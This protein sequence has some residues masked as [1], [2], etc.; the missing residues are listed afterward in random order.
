MLVLQIFNILGKYY[1]NG[2]GQL[3]QRYHRDF[4]WD[5]HNREEEQQEEEEQKQ[6]EQDFA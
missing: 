2:N 4:G 1:W 3:R 6:E 5:R